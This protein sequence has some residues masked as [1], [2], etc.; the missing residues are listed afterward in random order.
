[1]GQKKMKLPTVKYRRDL[2]QLLKEPGRIAEIGVAEGNFSRDMLEW[3]FP[4]GRPVATMLYMVDRWQ[5]TP[6]QAGDAAMPQSWHDDNLRQVRAKT[7]PHGSRVT[8]LRG[9]SAEMA[10]EL[11]DKFLS[12]LYI[13]ADH[14]YEGVFRDLRA[15]VPKVQMGGIVALHDYLNENYGV[16]KAVEAFC[17]SNFRIHVIK[18]DK[19]ED[20]GAWFEVC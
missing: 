2:W 7:K 18:E 9:D 3:N 12:L 1:M 17:S 5:E 14:S 19:P 15:W 20:A 6:E 13:D 4:D 10:E 8:T 16:R 11:P